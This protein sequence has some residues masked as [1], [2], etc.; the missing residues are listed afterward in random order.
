MSWLDLKKKVTVSL[1]DR[2]SHLTDWGLVKIHNARLS[3]ATNV[4]VRQRYTELRE[5]RHATNFNTS[6][7]ANWSAA[8]SQPTHSPDDMH[9]N[10]RLNAFVTMLFSLTMSSP[11]RVGFSTLDFIHQVGMCACLPFGGL[12][13]LN[14]RARLHH[15]PAQVIG[16]R[17]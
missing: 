5:L 2:L 14:G 10:S 17:G 7:T 11:C 13:F 3:I 6:P 8:Y 4:P 15:L 12:D 9:A 16:V 1:G